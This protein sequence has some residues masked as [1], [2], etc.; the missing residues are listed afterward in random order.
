MENFLMS[1]T[2]PVIKTAA[3][4]SNFAHPPLS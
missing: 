3:S 2:I 1:K 4:D